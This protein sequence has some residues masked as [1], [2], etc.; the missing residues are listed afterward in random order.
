MRIKASFAFGSTDVLGDLGRPF[1]RIVGA[2]VTVW[3]AGE[4][5]SKW[6]IKKWRLYTSLSSSNRNKV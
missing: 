5:M 6:D 4:E 2:E 1:Q 3:P